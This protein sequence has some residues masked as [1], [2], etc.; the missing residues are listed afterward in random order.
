[1]VILILFLRLQIWLLLHSH[2]ISSALW[3]QRLQPMTM[4]F[5]SKCASGFCVYSFLSLSLAFHG[6]SLLPRALSPLTIPFSHKL[7]LNSI[8]LYI[9][10]SCILYAYEDSSILLGEKENSYV[11]ISGFAIHGF[12]PSLGK[13]LSRLLMWSWS[14][15]SP[16]SIFSRQLS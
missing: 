16:I 8:L 7:L 13:R 5:I 12:T 4:S 6:A 2:Y 3:I 15:L 1:M 14:A 9:Y 11:L 10:V